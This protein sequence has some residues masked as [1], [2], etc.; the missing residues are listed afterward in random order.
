MTAIYS[1]SLPPISPSP[2]E[3]RSVEKSSSTILPRH[4]TDSLSERS[5]Y[6]GAQLVQSGFCRI[7]NQPASS[8]FRAGKRGRRG[9]WRVRVK[10]QNSAEARMCYSHPFLLIV[11]PTTT[12]TTWNIK[13]E[14]WIGVLIFFSLQGFQ[15]LLYFFLS[16][17]PVF[18]HSQAFSSVGVKVCE[19]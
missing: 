3:E 15:H 1:M 10:I 5:I 12:T 7:E 17:L 14:V 13:R 8:H 11:Q 2:C 9:L 4:V 19:I 6:L 16:F 18:F